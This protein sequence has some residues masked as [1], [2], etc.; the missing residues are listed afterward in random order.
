MRHLPALVIALAASGC[1]MQNASP[2]KKLSDSVHHLNEAARWGNLGSASQLVGPMYRAHY[3][4]T[5]RHWGSSIELADTDVVQVE[6][7]PDQESAVALVTYQW[8]LTSMMT[9]HQTVVRQH[10][11][12]FDGAYG[13]IEEV[14]VQGDARL[15]YPQGPGVGDPDEATADSVSLLGAE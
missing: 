15:L 3:I 6:M 2:G 13:L 8:Y 12:R 4:Q 14:V 9:L 7:S 5:H 11:S 1:F 10:W